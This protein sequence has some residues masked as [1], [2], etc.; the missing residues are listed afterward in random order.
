[1]LP[2]V[3][4]V[5]LGGFLKYLLMMVGLL[6]FLVGILYVFAR[7]FAVATSIVLEGRGA[8]GALARSSEL[9][10]GRKRHIL[11]TLLL[12]AIMYFFL[13]LGA[14]AVARLTGSSVVI[15][16]VSTA[17]T[18]VAYPVVGLTE[19]VLYYDARIR[20]EG[21]DIEMMARGLEPA[22]PGV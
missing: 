22:A 12:V 4:A 1:M 7:Y 11:N 15:L 20:A 5:L 9:S 17:F 6:C 21:F 19:M 8:V 13:S 16:V 3:P 2:R 14:T 18:I 10:R